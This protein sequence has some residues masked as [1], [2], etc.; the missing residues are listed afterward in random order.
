M[1][2]QVRGLWTQREGVRPQG[3]RLR[4]GERKAVT[5]LI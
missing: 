1:R 4:A 2:V 3:E 5:D